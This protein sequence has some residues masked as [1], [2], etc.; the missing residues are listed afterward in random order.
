[1]AISLAAKKIVWA[2]SRRVANERAARL[3]AV[4]ARKAARA[5]AKTRPTRRKP[6]RAGLLD[7][8]E[9]Y[10]EVSDVLDFA[11]AY[12]DLGDAVNSQVDDLL[13]GDEDDFEDLNENA[14]ALIER[15]L[16]GYLDELDSAIEDYIDWRN[17]QGHDEDEG[18]GPRGP[19]GPRR[20]HSGGSP[21]GPGA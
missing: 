3:D 6:A 4:A 21:F 19:Q 1:M 9:G 17:A 2:A 10:V 11:R 18:P 8:E 15:R 20:R 16:G 14:V 7:A 12:A 5:K 13:N